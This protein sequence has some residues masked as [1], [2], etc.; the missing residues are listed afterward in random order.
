MSQVQSIEK[1]KT[2]MEIGESLLTAIYAAQA[3]VK[4]FRGEDAR[5]LNMEIEA[6][7]PQEVG[8]GQKENIVKKTRQVRIEGGLRTAKQD[9]EWSYVVVSDIT[10][11][12]N[13]QW[14]TG[15]FPKHTE[16]FRVGWT[17]PVV[18]CEWTKSP[19]GEIVPLK[20]G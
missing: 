14:G 9:L 17:K 20:V 16:V 19:S 11:L 7:D 2:N 12:H 4:R 8:L 18:V 10:L 15:W 6:D 5:F 1:N 13:S 3:V